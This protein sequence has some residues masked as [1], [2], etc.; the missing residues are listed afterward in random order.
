MLSSS[1]YLILKCK[2]LIFSKLTRFGQN[3]VPRYLCTSIKFIFPRYET[4]F[5]PKVWPFSY[6]IKLILRDLTSR[7]FF[8]FVIRIFIAKLNTYRYPGSTLPF[9]YLRSIG[10]EA[11]KFATREVRRW[12]QSKNESDRR[13]KEN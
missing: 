6:C 11:A 2:Y 8:F 9:P 12:I 1:F 7:E 5:S 13:R 3:P 4:I 10:E